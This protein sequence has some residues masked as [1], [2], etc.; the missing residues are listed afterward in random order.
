VQD[1]EQPVGSLGLCGQA[2]R[3]AAGLDPLLAPAD[4]LGDRRLRDEERARDLGCRESSD[5]AQGE[6]YLRGRREGRMGAEEEQGDGVV[7]LRGVLVAWSRRE[8]LVGCHLCGGGLFAAPAC[9]SA[10]Q[11]VGYPQRR[12]GDQ[13]GPRVVGDSLLGPLEGGGEQR[14]LHRV[15]AH[16]EPAIA[17]DEHAEDLRRELAQQIL[18][19]A[20]GLS[21]ISAMYFTRRPPS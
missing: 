2:E 4:A 11:F 17:A 20:A 18:C 14:F 12:D 19:H 1:D 10:A 8:E 3:D 5:R 16:V 21:W 7:L 15:L 9:P 6:R 13:P